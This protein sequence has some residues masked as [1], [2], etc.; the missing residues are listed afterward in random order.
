MVA[1]PHSFARLLTFV[2]PGD[3]GSWYELCKGIVEQPSP[4][5]PQ[6]LVLHI[7]TSRRVLQC[8]WCREV[9]GAIRRVL[10]KHRHLPL[11]FDGQIE[12]LVS[13]WRWQCTGWNWTLLILPKVS[14]RKEIQWPI[15]QWHVPN[16]GVVIY[17]VGC[18]VCDGK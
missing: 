9:G 17:V 15:G 2:I 5:E 13:S 6:G 3:T 1:T 8:S 10:Q 11:G 12:C 7:C 18:K 4:Q 16:A 14:I